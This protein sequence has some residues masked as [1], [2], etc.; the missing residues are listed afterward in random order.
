M[1]RKKEYIEIPIALARLLVAE[2]KDLKHPEDYDGIQELAKAS[3]KVLI[4]SQ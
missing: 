2:P 3:L 4:L 1:N